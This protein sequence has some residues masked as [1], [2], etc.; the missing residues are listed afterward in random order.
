MPGLPIL[1]LTPRPRRVSQAASSMYGCTRR[2]GRRSSEWRPPARPRAI[3][4]RS[5]GVRME[6][7][8]K[9]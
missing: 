1:G 3:W 7:C 9:C 8:A 2:T 6:L 5:C 4:R